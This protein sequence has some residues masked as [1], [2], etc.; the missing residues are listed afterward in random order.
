MVEQVLE[1]ERVLEKTLEGLGQG[2]GQSSFALI[3]R[4]L[5]EVCEKPCYLDGIGVF[6]LSALLDECRPVECL[7][8]LFQGTLQMQNISG[9]F[10]KDLRLQKQNISSHSLNDEFLDSTHIAN[11]HIRQTPDE[12][13]LLIVSLPECLAQLQMA[14]EN[15]ILNHLET[16]SQ[17][18]W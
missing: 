8:D 6:W 16:L 14:K 5:F 2:D 15:T 11:E 3:R 13:I 4:C 1:Q 9:I 10:M 7:A 18:L 17:V 12:W